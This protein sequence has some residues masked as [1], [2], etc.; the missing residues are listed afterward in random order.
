MGP[1]LGT[2]DSEQQTIIYYNQTKYI[3]GCMENVRTYSPHHA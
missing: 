2:S 3:I 1:I